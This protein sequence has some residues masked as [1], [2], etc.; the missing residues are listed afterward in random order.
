MSDHDIIELYKSRDEQAIQETIDRYGKY[1]FRIAF[2]ILQN[3]EDVEECL[4]DTWNSV[5]QKIPPMIPRSL[6]AFLVKLV[7][8]HALTKYRFNHAAK[9]FH[10]FD[11]LLSE[12]DECIPD[13]TN[14]EKTIEDAEL[15]NCISCW[16]RTKT[17]KEQIIFVKRYY[18]G[19]SVKILANEFLCTEN[20]MT[21]K[22]KRLRNNLK[23]Y[24]I[25][26]GMKNE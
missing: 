5:W 8:D 18:H 2:N 7:R 25:K 23:E 15:S 9:R 22:L 3:H 11:I 21:L 4:N 12:L 17:R 16:L 1:C 20:T 10:E 19:E 24:L 13:K 26:E 6:K 14:I